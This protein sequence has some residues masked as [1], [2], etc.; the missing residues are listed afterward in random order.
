MKNGK[1]HS[2]NGI[3]SKTMSLALCLAAL[4]IW[5]TIPLSIGDA[6]KVSAQ[7]Q[8]HSKQPDLWPSESE[9]HARLAENFKP[10]R[11]MLQRKGVPFEPDLLLSTTG[12]KY[13]L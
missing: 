8:T 9:Q 10:A 12:K 4:L 13:T 7:Q 6:G 5:S 1:R 2:S 11:D 3:L